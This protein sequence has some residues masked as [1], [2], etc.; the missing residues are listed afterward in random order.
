MIILLQQQSRFFQIYK[1]ILHI[2]KAKFEEAASH[3]RKLQ[4]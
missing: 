1:R 4:K 2:K 3:T